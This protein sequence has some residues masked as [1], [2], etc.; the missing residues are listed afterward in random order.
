MTP[1]S[2][3]DLSKAH[4]AVSLGVCLAIWSAIYF[5]LLT[6][7]VSDFNNFVG[8][9]LDYIRLHGGFAA[10]SDDFS[11]Y[12]PP[13]L[14]LLAAVSYFDFPFSDQVL[15]KL[16]N[17]PF[18]ALIGVSVFK[19]C[20]HFELS[21]NTAF[22]AG[23]GVLLVPTL[24]I[25]AFIWGQAD[26]LYTPLL[27]LSVLMVLKR[28]PYWAV[29][30]FAAAVSIKLQGIFLA[31]FF[32][33]AVLA[34][35]VPWR[36]ALVA[37]F[38]YIA[39]ILPAALIGRPLSELV[40]IYLVQGKFYHQLSMNAPNFYFFLDYLFGASRNP[41]VYK[42]VTVLGLGLASAAGALIGLMGFAHRRVS[43]RAVLM[44]AT[45]SM[46]LMPFVLP[47]M[48]DRFFFGADMFAYA[49]AWVDRRFIWAALGLQIGSMLSFAPEFSWYALPGG[50]E[51]W[52]WAV[53]LG[54][55]VNSVVIAYIALLL[56]RELGVFLNAPRIKRRL[57]ALLRLGRRRLRG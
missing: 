26:T 55:L 37:P 13:Y 44:A 5:P 6:F 16:V 19:L 8:P 11:E 34:A 48:H 47:K 31:P 9:W 38:V 27:L 57:G 17:A 35:R 24:G 4:P 39:S 36:A 21:R 32:L 14:Y 56:R 25:N 29:G 45:L 1:L 15:V 53:A 42:V 46:A 7:S 22:V 54:A 18:V 41:L 30:L 23:C 33:F 49:L 40:T 10:L 20:R 52:A 2:R 50:P 12:A 43:D 51:H 3:L 28:R